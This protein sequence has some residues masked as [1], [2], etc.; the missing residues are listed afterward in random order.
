VWRKPQLMESLPGQVFWYWELTM[1]RVTSTLPE[2]PLIQCEAQAT[3]LRGVSQHK[4]FLYT[5]PAEIR[6]LRNERW[7]FNNCEVILTLII[8]WLAPPLL[9]PWCFEATLAIW[10]E[11]LAKGSYQKTPHQ[12]WGSNLQ[13]LKCRSKLFTKWVSVLTR[14][15]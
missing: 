8:H 6:L 11:R 14:Y 4:P 5:S 7:I 9:L 12:Q 13:S 2:H 3:R 1:P 15:S 10:S